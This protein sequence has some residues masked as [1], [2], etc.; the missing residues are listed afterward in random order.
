MRE[1]LVLRPQ[2]VESRLQASF[3][4]F[5]LSREAMRC[6]PKTLEHYRYTDQGEH[7][8]RFRIRPEATPE[9][10][11][12]QTE[13]SYDPGPLEYGTTYYWRIDEVNAI[14]TT[15]G[16]VWSFTVAP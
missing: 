7:H 1:H 2:P 11:A 6:T 12:N 16:T 13:T 9:L 14:G 3:A 15:T 4:A 5:M 10:V 8:F